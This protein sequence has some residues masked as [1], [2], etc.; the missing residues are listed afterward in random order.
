VI[1]NKTGCLNPFCGVRQ[2]GVFVSAEPLHF[3]QRDVGA[4]SDITAGEGP[5]RGPAEKESGN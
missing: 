3:S 2:S 5:R 1:M 4:R